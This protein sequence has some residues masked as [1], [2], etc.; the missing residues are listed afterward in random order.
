VCGFVIRGLIVCLI[1][2]CVMNTTHVFFL[3][4]FAA[5]IWR[6]S[7]LWN[8]VETAVNSRNNLHITAEFRGTKFCSVGCYYVEHLETS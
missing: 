2:L 3:C 8:H 5:S 6:D 4:P 7:G 1:V